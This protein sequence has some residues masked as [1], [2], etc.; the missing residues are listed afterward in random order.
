MQFESLTSFK[1]FI[2]HIPKNNINNYIRRKI[3]KYE[4]GKKDF[5]NQIVYNNS[6]NVVNE[7]TNLIN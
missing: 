1:D 7:Y 4:N 3:E 6:K 2:N 5:L